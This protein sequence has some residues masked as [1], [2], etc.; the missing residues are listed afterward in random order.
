MYQRRFFTVLIHFKTSS[1]INLGS[2]LKGYLLQTTAPFKIYWLFHTKSCF[3]CETYTWWSQ[4]RLP[5]PSQTSERLIL[6]PEIP[7]EMM[8]ANPPPAKVWCCRGSREPKSYGKSRGTRLRFKPGL[9][10]MQKPA[11]VAGVELWAPG[12][13]ENWTSRLYI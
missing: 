1:G 3:G 9:S 4:Q 6:H 10:L 8:D 11:A 2:F 7:A 13:F 12:R 5:N